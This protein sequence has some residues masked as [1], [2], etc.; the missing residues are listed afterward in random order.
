MMY[1]FEMQILIGI[2]YL[3]CQNECQVKVSTDW[4]YRMLSICW[5]KLHFLLKNG[6]LRQMCIDLQMEKK[7]TFSREI[8]ATS[9]AFL[10]VLR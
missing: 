3:I 7:H 8:G 4:R 10:L 5:K 1:C 9:S 6:L 2:Y